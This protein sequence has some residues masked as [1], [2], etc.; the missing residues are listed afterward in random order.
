MEQGK[1]RKPAGKGDMRIKQQDHRMQV[2][3]VHT[4]W[5]PLRG[6]EVP[7]EV[8]KGPAGPGL[9]GVVDPRAQRAGS[10]TLAL[11]WGHWL[12]ACLFAV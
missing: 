9:Q 8:D 3:S 6:C 10:Q 2:S 1:K 12:L 4:A 7:G 11:P 5:S